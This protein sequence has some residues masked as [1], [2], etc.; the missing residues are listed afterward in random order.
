LSSSGSRGGCQRELF[1][2]V[3]PFQSATDDQPHVFRNV[4]LVDFDISAELAGRVK[5]LPILDQMPV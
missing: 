1:V 4:A 3:E 5:D 2:L